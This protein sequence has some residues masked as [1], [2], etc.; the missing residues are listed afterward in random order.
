MTQGKPTK[1][2]TLVIEGRRRISSSWNDG[3]EMIEEFDVK[4]NELLLRKT[5][6]PTVLGGEGDWIIEVGSAASF[7]QFDPIKDVIAP[8]G[9]APIFSRLDTKDFFQWRIRNLPYS[10]SVFNLS[11]ENEEIVVRTTNK[12]YFKKIQLPDL[13]RIDLKMEQSSL[14]WKLQHNTLVISYKKPRKAIDAEL[15]HLQEAIKNS[16]TL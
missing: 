4:S 3:S 10:E 6:K 9:S 12:K 14:T 7:K 11:I 8:S 1:V 13:T 5:R 16:L 2:V 15:E